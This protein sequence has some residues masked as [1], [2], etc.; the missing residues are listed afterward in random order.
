MSSYEA[1][2]AAALLLV[3]SVTGC[4][5]APES[6]STNK[7]IATD[8]PDTVGG[9]TNLYWITANRIFRGTC[10]LSGPAGVPAIPANCNLNPRSMSYDDF[11]TQLDGGLSQTITD[12]TNEAQR[13]QDVITFVQEQI[14]QTTQDIIAAEQQ[15]G[16]LT[17]ELQRL[18]TNMQEFQV[19][20]TELHDQLTLINQELRRLNN[21]DLMMQRDI[22]IVQM[23]EYQGKVSDIVARIPQI[24]AQLGGILTQ[25]NAL[26]TQLN[27]LS[28]RLS[29]LQGD[30]SQVNARLQ[31]ACDDFAVYGETLTMLQSGITYSVFANN[32]IAARNRQFVKRFE[33]IFVAVP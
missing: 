4:S 29:N 1:I 31:S 8:L 19:F 33:M 16:P 5:P 25:V 6:V 23:Q 30:L 10:R 3:V 7:N 17:A 32:V 20:V 27:S 22:V 28:T 11:K 14:S 2:L 18:R 24:T 15:G 9:P 21:Q 26:R 13:V 12:L